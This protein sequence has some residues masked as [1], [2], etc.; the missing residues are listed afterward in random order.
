MEIKKVTGSC[1]GFGQTSHAPH[2]YFARL[3]GAVAL[4]LVGDND[5][6][7]IIETDKYTL[8]VYDVFGQFALQI[9]IGT[10]GMYP[11]T[12][13][14]IDK[15]YRNTASPECLVAAAEEHMRLV[16]INK[17]GKY[18]TLLE[19]RRRAAGLTQKQLAERSGVHANIISRVENETQ[20]I[21]KCTFDTILKL[22][23]ALECR[24][25][26]LVNGT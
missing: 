18:N 19:R 16:E 21:G 5:P 3:D 26:N 11:W 8:Y 4:G 15:M 2:D 23:A 6:I 9:V 7:A 14:D 10:K 1:F 17:D 24:P 25:E 20:P 13:I 22:S 12:S